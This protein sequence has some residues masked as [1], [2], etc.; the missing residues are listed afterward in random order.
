VDIARRVEQV[1]VGRAV[2]TAFGLDLPVDHTSVREAR[3]AV[4]SIEA[5]VAQSLLCDAQLIVSELVTNALRHGGLGP[6]DLIALTVTR[7]G[8]RVRIDVDDG[9]WFTADSETFVYPRHD[10]VIGGRGLR[11]VQTLAMRWQAL[12]GRVSVWLDIPAAPP[13]V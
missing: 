8:A 11:L 13:P 10:G 12:N 3:R 2:E 4:E 6:T 9:G 1:A 5:L 7:Q